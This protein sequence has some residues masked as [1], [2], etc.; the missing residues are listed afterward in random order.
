MK[1]IVFQ[2]YGE[3]LTYDVDINGKII[4]IGESK[5]VA[6]TITEI[7]GKK[8]RMVKIILFVL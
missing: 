8:R 6:Q 1:I 3:A 4:P 5:S 7:T 2:L